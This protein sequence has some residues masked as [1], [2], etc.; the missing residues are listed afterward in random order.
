M[1]NYSKFD[2]TATPG[3]LTGISH[4]D[5]LLSIDKGF[6]SA[7]IFLTGTS[8]AGKTTLAK[9]IQK[10]LVNTPTAL[11]E[12]E[13]SSKSVAKQTRR[14]VIEHENAML[15]DETD[16]P[17]FTDF[18]NAVEE[19]GIKFIIIDS[20]QTAAT[21][22]ERNNGMGE[23]ES[24]LEVLNVLMSWKKRTGGTAILIGMVKKDGDFSGLNKIKHLA[25]CHLHMV[26]DE[27]RNIRH[28]HTTKNRDNST[29]KIY[30]E[31]VSTDEVIVFYTEKEFELKGK[32]YKFDD[33]LMSVVIDFFSGVDKK[34]PSYKDFLKEYNQKVA[35]IA[36]EKNGL[37]KFEITISIATMINEVSK[38][39]GL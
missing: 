16:Y 32:N 15:C 14:I 4:V 13:T 12:R 24:Q 36:E 27:K 22:F 21:D 3:I 20:L 34:Q 30:Y 28:M 26:F 38:K 31:F 10:T 8:G 1:K 29:T 2:T 37:S 5:N 11:Y 35:E 9:L 19:K 6:Q 39:Y 23:N 25:D 17:T 7:I 33:Y 18:M